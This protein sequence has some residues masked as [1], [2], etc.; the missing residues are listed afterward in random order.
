MDRFRWAKGKSTWG[1]DS[2]EDKSQITEDHVYYLG[3][4]PKVSGTIEVF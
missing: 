1:D 2:E 3:L 4:D